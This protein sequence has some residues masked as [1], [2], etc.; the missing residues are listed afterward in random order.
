MTEL[1]TPPSGVPVP[2]RAAD[3]P[4]HW[5]VRPATIRRLWIVSIVVLTLL[6]LLDLLIPKHGH[7]GLEDSFGFGSWYGFASCVVLVLVSRALGFVLK[8]PDGYYDD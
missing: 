5:L 7:F 3:E 2:V 1:P 4:Q 6:T 8:R